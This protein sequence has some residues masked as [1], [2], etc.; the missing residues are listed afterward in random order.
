[1]KLGE[2]LNLEIAMVITWI[3][4]KSVITNGEDT[5]PRRTTLRFS[6]VVKCELQCLFFY[7]RSSGDHIKLTHHQVPY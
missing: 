7:S 3:A 6:R 1:M 4:L 5:S 2:K